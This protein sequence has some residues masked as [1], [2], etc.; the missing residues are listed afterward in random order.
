MTSHTE[1]SRQPFEELLPEITAKFLA[2]AAQIFKER[3]FVPYPAFRGGHAQTLGAYAWPR[4]RSLRNVSDEERLF[5]VEP[6]TKIL[7]HCRWQMDRSRHPALILV[8]GIEGS[9]SSVYM[10]SMAMKAFAA[11]F[12][13]L[14]LN[15]RT[16]GGTEHL[17]PTIYHGGLSGDLRAVVEE[18]TLE[19]RI[20]KIFLAGFSLG[21]NLVLKLAGEYGPQVP[22]EVIAVC[23]VSPSVNLRA[24][25]DLIGKRSNWIYEY[26]FVR[27]LKNRIRSKQRLFPAVYKLDGIS[28]VRTLRDFDERF[29]APASGFKDADDYY[30]RSSSIHVID[31]IKVP[32]LIIHAQ[33]DPFIPFAPLRDPRVAANPYILFLDPEIGGHVAFVSSKRNVTSNGEDRFW[34]ENRVM[35]FCSLANEILNNGKSRS[36]L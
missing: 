9:S 35:D 15:L 22:N 28:L 7:A 8:H 19:D 32:T 21:G 36:A 26:D 13:V 30:Q 10:L 1:G 11:G 34:A 4:R 24:S 17:T 25:S 6:G 16:C 23:A 31:R 14:R 20:E 3:E 5:E 2:Q 18:L 29:T 12:N 33:D 27:R